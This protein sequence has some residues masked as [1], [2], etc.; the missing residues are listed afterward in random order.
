MQQVKKKFLK[1]RFISSLL[2]V[3]VVAVGCFQ[4]TPNTFQQTPQSLTI[5][6]TIPQPTATAD[7]N[8]QLTQTAVVRNQQLLAQTQTSVAATETSIALQPTSTPAVT[9]VMQAVTLTPSTTFVVPVQPGTPGLDAFQA[10]TTDPNQVATI[11]PNIDSFAL[12][13]TVQ[14]LRVTQTVQFAQTQTAIA[15]FGVTATPP[16][17][18]P[19]AQ[20]T[21]APPP[22]TDCVHEIKAG[23]NLYRLSVRY[24]VLVMTIA[25]A[26]GI[27]NINFVSVGQRVTIP[28]CGTTGQVPPPT[29]TPRVTLTP[30][31]ITGGG[32]TGNPPTTGVTYIVQEGDTLGQIANRYNT[33]ANAIASASGITNINLIRMGDEITIPQ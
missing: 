11:D 32:Q 18:I 23:E 5:Q 20:Q 27:G 14:I 17:T 9:V 33:T 29:S 26:N 8:D 31:I 25:G 13:S 3:L 22:G 24:G 15:I 30:T 6:P 7:P 10:A 4:A 1:A 16:P 21:A 2:I 12:T 19:I 28:N